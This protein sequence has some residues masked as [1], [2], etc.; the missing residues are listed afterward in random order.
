[1]EKRKANNRKLETATC[2]TGNSCSDERQ[3]A[4]PTTTLIPDVPR[5]Q[6]YLLGYESFRNRAALRQSTDQSRALVDSIRS[7]TASAVSVGIGDELFRTSSTQIGDSTGSGL[8]DFTDAVDR[9]VAF[10][11]LQLAVKTTAPANTIRDSI[12]SSA[13][14]KELVLTITEQADEDSDGSDASQHDA[15]QHDASHKA[16]RL[17]TLDSRLESAPLPKSVPRN[18]GSHTVIAF[19]NSASGGGKGNEVFQALTKSIGENFVYDLKNCTP[20]NMPDDILLNYSHDPQV[21]VLVCGGDGTCGWIYSCL[22]NVWSTVLRRW[23]GQVHQSSFKDHLPIAIMPLGTG[24]DLSRQF[25]WGKRFTSNMLN[26]SE[27]LAVKNGT[28]KHLDRWR[29][30]ILPAKTVDDE[31]KKAI[32]QILNEEIRESHVTT[33]PE[34]EVTSSILESLL[35]DSDAMKPSSRFS[36]RESVT[37]QFFDGVFCNYFSLGFDA[38]IAYRF[39][40]ERELHP[41]KFTS[42]LKNKMVYVMKSPAALRAPKL[43]K[44]VKLLVNDESGRLVKLPVPDDCR[45][46]ILMNIQSFGGGNKL[47]SA[48]VAN[49]GL[50]EVIFVSNLPRA[51]ATCATSKAL[52]FVRFKVAAQTNRVCFRTKCPL[53]CQVDGEPWLQEEGVIQVKFHSRNSILKNVRTGSSCNCSGD[54]TG[55][56]VR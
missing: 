38:T 47:S 36:V 27:I 40:N 12:V 44:R 15:P 23:N 52:P 48:G 21:R 55:A 18:A 19:V 54:P 20:G 4:P 50:I 7:S 32:P 8:I 53:H 14:S 30:L 1:M 43:K 31:A 39:H 29:L 42:P 3:T 6:S 45:S 49:D 2:D 51:V 24:N 13:L 56:V 33:R 16:S 10:Q 25:G 17:T 35:E 22:D 28:V 41:E 11:R 46:I 34:S 37:S 9:I 5:K 26:K